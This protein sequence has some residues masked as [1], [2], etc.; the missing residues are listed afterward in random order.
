MKETSTIK[1]NSNTP[2]LLHSRIKLLNALFVYKNK[3]QQFA[4]IFSQQLLKKLK[5]IHVKKN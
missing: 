4:D 1:S 3:T 5:E 2:A